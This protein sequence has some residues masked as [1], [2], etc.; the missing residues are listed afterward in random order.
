[1][2]YHTLLRL[3]RILS[4]LGMKLSLVFVLKMFL[5]LSQGTGCG[6]VQLQHEA[7]GT[8]KLL[9]Y[10]TDDTACL[11]ATRPCCIC[12]I[13]DSCSCSV[14][15]CMCVHVRVCA[16]IV[17]IS[18]AFAAPGFVHHT[19][20]RHTLISQHSIC[21]TC[22]SCKCNCKQVFYDIPS[23][24]IHFYVILLVFYFNWLYKDNTALLL[25]GYYYFNTASLRT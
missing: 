1:M 4:L 17:F 7:W 9:Y 2:K 24:R 10:W 12:L 15:L 5:W 3:S 21:S 11:L 22:S 6:L 25:L 16:N 19:F 18:K 23:Q 8:G 14:C 20:N 13:N